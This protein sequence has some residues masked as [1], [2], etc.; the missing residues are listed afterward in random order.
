[1][2]RGWQFAYYVT[3]SAFLIGLRRHGYVQWALVS[4]L[5][6]LF[7][8]SL[9]R[10]KRRGHLHWD[11]FGFQPPWFGV[12]GGLF[13]SGA[14]IGFLLSRHPDRVF[15]AVCLI[16]GALLVVEGVVTRVRSGK[17]QTTGA[18]AKESEERLEDWMYGPKEGHFWR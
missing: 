7:L 16:S 4:P 13:F 8:A 17:W 12:V 2:A 11:D 5:V 1:M 6:L 15:G 18:A 9:A 3:L 10:R 14:G